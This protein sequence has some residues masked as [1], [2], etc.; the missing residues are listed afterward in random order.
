MC[1]ICG[2][3]GRADEKLTRTMTGLL[4][5]RGPDGEGVRCFPAADGRAPAA[6]GHRRLSILDPTPRGA[7]P[8]SY[9]DERYWITYNGEL[10]NFR[11]LRA[12]LERDG[13]SFRSDCDTEVLLAMYARYGAELVERLKGIFAF[14]IWDAVAG[15]L[16]LAR[17]RLGVKPLYYAEH[18][19]ALYFASEVKALLPALPPARMR[20]DVLGQY[21]SLLWVPDPDTLF[22]GVYTLAPGHCAR[23]ADGRLSSRCY[24]DMSYDPQQRGA[25]HWAGELR[26][27]VSDAV[28]RQMVSDVPIGAFL[29]GGIDSSAIVAAMTEAS[30]QVATYTVGFSQEDLRHEIVPDDIRYAREVGRAFGADYHEEIL[31]P[32]VVDLLPRLIW[33]MDVPVADPACIS[34]Y[35]ICAA[36]RPRSTVLLSGMGGDEIFAGY[37]RHL[38]ARLTRFADALPRPLRTTLRETIERRLTLGDPGRMRG[39]RRNLR[40]L[41]GAIDSPPVERYL[42]YCSYYR[43]A[44][45]E[46][47]LSSELRAGMGGPDPLHRHRAYAERVA[48]EHWL[49]QLLYV[50]MKTFLPC[51]NLTYTDKM[52]MA[53][54]T[55]VR[56]PLLDDEVVALT[57]RIPP[58]LK[59]RRLTRKYIFKRSMEGVL[60]REV[61]RRP[62]AGFGAPVRS[63]LMGD[64]A[65]MVDELLSAD[66]VTR[67]GLFDH[68]EV[69]RLIDDNA[70]NRADN[71]LRIWALMTLELWQRTF[72]DREGRRG[73]GANPA[74]LR[75]DPAPVPDMRDSSGAARGRSPA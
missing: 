40:K 6:L 18:D 57:G 68:R 67:R 25:S 29:S 8:M 7:Q 32:N 5:H 49:N 45:L 1:G 52:S 31:A 55:E 19:G 3:V 38:A 37:P 58:E 64:L 60:P 27:T 71:A 13:F 2:C 74:S 50:D 72:I 69:R 53:A 59:L 65:P 63:W 62:K 21:L 30:P 56:V 17:D 46:R 73:T 14:A 41:A 70:A 43:R 4:A 24:W 35:L 26:E 9:A 34:T 66:A 42:A 47:L 28:R 75:Q 61:I 15:E 16:F 39:P 51:L 20:T 12:E 11:A 10:Y 48:G 54:S 44:E 36:A 33:H 22:E 23:V